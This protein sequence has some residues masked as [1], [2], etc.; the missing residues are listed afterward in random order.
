M[1]QADAFIDGIDGQNM[2]HQSNDV[3]R[4]QQQMQ[5]IHLYQQTHN[6][7]QPNSEAITSQTNVLQQQQEAMLMQQQQ[8]MLDA[9]N[10]QTQQQFFQ[11]ADEQLPPEPFYVAGSCARR[12][13]TYMFMQQHIPVR[14]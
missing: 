2:L 5:D 12:L 8:Q 7:V 9:P 11:N 4:L 6:F 14:L 13:S 1:A 3:M 10:F